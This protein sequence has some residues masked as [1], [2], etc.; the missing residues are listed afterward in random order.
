MAA[1]NPNPSRITGAMWD[2]WLWFDQ[3]E[4]DVQLG[5]IFAAKGGYH[6]IRAGHAGDYSV[7]E[8]STD[9]EGPSDKASAIDLTMGAAGMRK[10]TGR[11]DA[12]AKARDERLF[13]GGQAI[14]R[15]FIGTKD[16]SRVY[17]YVL[18]GGWARGLGSDASE[19]WGRDSSHLWHLH[20]SVIR[21]FCASADAMDR[22][23]SVL[24]G[25]S[26]SSWR[27]RRT[28]TTP[29]PVQ[30]DDMPITI[31]IQI[32]HGFAYDANDDL[33]ANGES[34]VSI[35]LPPCG[36][37]D[38]NA[39]WNTKRAY[40]SLS[41]D[42]ADPAAAPVVRVA[43]NNGGGWSVKHVT[44]VSGARVNVELPAAGNPQGFNITVGRKDT[45]VAEHAVLPLGLMV[46]IL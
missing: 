39:A 30:E 2:F 14:I 13:I 11:L 38:A 5:G 26:I 18:V 28:P 33:V 1:S 31:P 10:Y 4:A 43:V 12:A 40:L 3:L 24:A 42:H 17:C 9:R 23:W 45:G 44:V 15:E 37:K 21:K 16:S 6:D 41:G 32:P 27:A 19:D 22:L 7:A 35:P 25:E 36:H 8:V 46:E 20:I 29:T 34:A